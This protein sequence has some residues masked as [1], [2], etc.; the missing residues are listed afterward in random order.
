MGGGGAA[1]YSH[2]SYLY[3]YISNGKMVV[4]HTYYMIVYIYMQ[5]G[6]KSAVVG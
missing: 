1:I 6:S 2:I 5:T 3:I 4:S